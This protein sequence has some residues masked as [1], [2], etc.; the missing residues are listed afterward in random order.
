MFKLFGR[1]FFVKP[2]HVRIKFDIPKETLDAVRSGLTRHKNKKIRF[3]GERP[4]S[5]T[6]SR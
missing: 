3:L 1:Y 4:F 5:S 2:E 6:L